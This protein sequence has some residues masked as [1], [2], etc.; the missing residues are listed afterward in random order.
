MHKEE[1]QNKSLCERYGSLMW[2]EMSITQS[3]HFDKYSFQFKG[4]SYLYESSSACVEEK[5]NF[6]ALREDWTQNDEAKCTPDFPR[7]IV[8]SYLVDLALVLIFRQYKTNWIQQK[9]LGVVSKLMPVHLNPNSFQR[10]N[11]KLAEQVLSQL[12]ECPDETEIAACGVASSNNL[13]DKTLLLNS[14]EDCPN[15]FPQEQKDETNPTTKTSVQV[16]DL[17]QGSWVTSTSGAVDRYG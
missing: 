4:F 16:V 13:Q 9:A 3:I 14:Y 8:F 5:N 6:S 11:V 12:Y 2:D 1:I 7:T 17:E 10:M 15:H